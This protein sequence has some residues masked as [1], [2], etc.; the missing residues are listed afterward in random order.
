MYKKQKIEI[1]I[2]KELH[3]Q[4]LLS[5]YNQHCWIFRK[6]NLQKVKFRFNNKIQYKKEIKFQNQVCGKSAQQINNLLIFKF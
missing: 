6:D 5:A 4:N 1:M 2:E 3:A